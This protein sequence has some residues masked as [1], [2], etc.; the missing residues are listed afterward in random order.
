MLLPPQAVLDMNAASTPVPDPSLRI[1][2]PMIPAFFTLRKFEQT[3]SPDRRPNTTRMGLNRVSS[4]CQMRA[5]PMSIRSAD[6]AG[7]VAEAQI[8]P[9]RGYADQYCAPVAKARHITSGRRSGS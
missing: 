2:P 9:G 6:I 1:P 4:V 5:G 7:S 8:P 3:S